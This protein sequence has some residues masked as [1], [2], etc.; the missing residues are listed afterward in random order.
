[1]EKTT[2]QFMNDNGEYVGR[3]LDYKFIVEDWKKSM[4]A[5]EDFMIFLT[6]SYLEDNINVN[7]PLIGML[8]EMRRRNRY[9][10]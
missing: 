6:K 1:M 5:N 10:I 4:L 7:I 3:G 9:G 8:N 2:H